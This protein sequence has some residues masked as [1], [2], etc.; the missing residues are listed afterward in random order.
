MASWLPEVELNRDPDA[1]PDPDDLAGWSRFY[2]GAF[3]EHENDFDNCRW[4]KGTWRYDGSCRCGHLL[5]VADELER[6]NVE[7]ANLNA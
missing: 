1:R 3:Y 2:A 4:G 7:I 5:A 6:L